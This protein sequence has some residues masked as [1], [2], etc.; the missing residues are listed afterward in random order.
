[1]F[2]PGALCVAIAAHLWLNR[3]AHDYLEGY[4]GLALITYALFSVLEGDYREGFGFRTASWPKPA[5]KALRMFDSKWAYLT[6]QV[7]AALS[8]LYLIWM[9]HTLP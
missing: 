1:L 6:W 3:W 4:A 2:L 9:W 5:S 7:L 8:G